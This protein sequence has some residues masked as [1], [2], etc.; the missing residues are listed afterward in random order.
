MLVGGNYQ[1]EEA[2]RVVVGPV[3]AHAGMGITLRVIGR[4]A[5]EANILKVT[6]AL[7]TEQV[8]RKLV[9]GDG[10]INPPIP[11]IVRDRDPQGIAVSGGK[12][13]FARLV[14]KGT[15]AIIV[16]QTG[17][18]RIILCWSARREDAA[19][20]AEL[21]AGR[22]EFHIVRDA[23]VEKTIRIDI[24]KTVAGSPEIAAQS[25]LPADFTKPSAALVV[26]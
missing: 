21:F 13:A 19:E 4:S 17:F 5:G 11:I 3:D 15:V 24:H 8:S 10:D 9:I 16:V 7:I 18:L 1:L 2:V 20:L 23:E 26:I 12:A 22:V 14:R 25:R 6:I